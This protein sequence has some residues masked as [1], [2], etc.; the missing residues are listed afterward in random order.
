MGKD[1]YVP[2]VP[3]FKGGIKTEE[4]FNI[5]KEFTRELR[6]NE[7]KYSDTMV[8]KFMSIVDKESYHAFI[9]YF[10]KDIIKMMDII[11]HINSSVPEI[12]Y[13]IDYVKYGVS[14]LSI[15]VSKYKTLQDL[16]NKVLA[17]IIYDKE[18]DNILK[19]YTLL[20]K[21]YCV[22]LFQSISA[23][24]RHKKI[25][26]VIITKDEFDSLNKLLFNYGVLELQFDGTR[27]EM[28]AIGSAFYDYILPIIYRKDNYSSLISKYRLN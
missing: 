17:E 28:T 13:N 2:I 7:S 12:Q 26:D 24:S 23:L 27:Y 6:I 3:V 4:D 25:K 10:R 11:D 19:I 18:K 15:F 8:D 5:F 21:Y 9:N 22:D 20:E 16:S 1:I 14:I